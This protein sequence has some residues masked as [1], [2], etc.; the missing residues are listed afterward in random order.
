MPPRR[1]FGLAANESAVEDDELPAIGDRPLVRRVLGRSFGQGQHRPSFTA[2]W[3]GNHDAESGRALSQT[4]E[5]PPIPSALQPAGESYS[6][7]VPLLSMIVLSIV[8]WRTRAWA[9]I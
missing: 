6:T 1:S 2:R 8:S 5:R 7:P 3:R 4:G 9:P